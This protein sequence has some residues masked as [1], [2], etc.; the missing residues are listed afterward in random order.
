MRLLSI[1]VGLPL[2][3]G[4]EGAPDADGRPWTTGYGKRPVPSARVGL[5]NLEGDG[6]ADHRHHGGPEMAVLAYGADH[7]AG[8]RRELDWPGMPLGAFAENLSVEGADEEGVCIGDV[9]E[10]GEARLQVSEP[11]K[12]CRNI[13]RYWERRDLLKQVERSGRFGWYLRVLREGRLAAGQEVRLAAR[14]QP[15]WPVARAM[16]ARL[17]KAKD[18]AEAHALAALPELG[19]DWRAKLLEPL[20][21]G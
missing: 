9:W 13:S 5:L 4:H 12:P 6:Q 15:L 17:G 16:R 3:L 14:P 8:W 7:Y 2:R 21:A 20:K 1:Q 18:L 11:R 10:V 19:A